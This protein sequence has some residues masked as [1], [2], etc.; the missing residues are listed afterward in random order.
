MAM[1]L[2]GK[3]ASGATSGFGV[4]SSAGL[5]AVPDSTTVSNGAFVARDTPFMAAG[6]A[7][8]QY[9]RTAAPTGTPNN[10]IVSSGQRFTISVGQTITSVT[11]ERGGIQQIFG[12][13][14]ISTVIKAGGI[15]AVGPDTLGD[16]GSAASTIIK[17]GGLQLVGGAVAMSTIIDSGGVQYVDDAYP[18][19]GVESGVAISTTIKSGGI[20]YLVGRVIGDDIVISSGGILLLEPDYMSTPTTS[21]VK[22]RPGGIELTVFGVSAQEPFTE[23]DQIGSGIVSGGTVASLHL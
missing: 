5:G 8:D 2:S 9:A 20:E 19:D 7:A 17:L 23:I 13:T 15:Q 3:T 1:I 21:D 16:F 22:I 14:A 12:G 11:I 18:S 10:T 6:Q 4:I